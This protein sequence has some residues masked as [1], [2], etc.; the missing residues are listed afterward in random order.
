[1]LLVMAGV[2]NAST[3]GGTLSTLGGTL[4]TLGDKEKAHMKSVH[5]IDDYDPWTFF[6]MHDTNQDK[7]LDETELKHF[8]YSE[9][10]TATADQE[11]AWLEGVFHGVDFN[12]DGKISFEDYKRPGFE[13]HV[14]SLSGQGSTMA[15]HVKKYLHTGGS[16]SN[17]QV[18]VQKDGS[19]VY[20]YHN[21]PL[22]Y[23]V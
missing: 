2:M 21:V 22:K 4:S 17:T 3:F 19:K 15:D 11:K 5:G 20:V 13:D 9:Y 12:S 1:M 6:T 14:F 8:L 10:P 18:T 16:T 23:R 7:V